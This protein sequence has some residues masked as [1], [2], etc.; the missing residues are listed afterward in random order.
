[1]SIAEKSL[2]PLDSVIDRFYCI[3]NNYL[4][5]L[6][7]IDDRLKFCSYTFSNYIHTT[8]VYYLLIFLVFTDITVWILVWSVIFC[9]FLCISQLSL[10]AI[11]NSFDFSF[12]LIYFL[13]KTNLIHVTVIH[14]ENVFIPAWAAH[15]ICIGFLTFFQYAVSAP[16]HQMCDWAN[17]IKE[18][19]QQTTSVN[20]FRTLIEP[21]IDKLIKPETNK[22]VKS[23]QLIFP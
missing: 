19:F 1:M 2:V 3:S 13:W 16:I 9:P 7:N 12:I 21:K 23:N 11:I 4:S 18:F 10:F 14:Y 6:R 17:K 20:N 8:Q 22:L 15:W 5:A